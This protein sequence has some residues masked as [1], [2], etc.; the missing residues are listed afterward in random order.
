MLN[1]KYK[2]FKISD[3]VYSVCFEVSKIGINKINLK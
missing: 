3:Y 2:I 1:D